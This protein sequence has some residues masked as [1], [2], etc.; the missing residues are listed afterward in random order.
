M[1]HTEQTKLRFIH[2]KSQ[3]RV[4]LPYVCHCIH[5]HT[6]ITDKTQNPCHVGK[7]QNCWIL[8]YNAQHMSH[9]DVCP[10]QGSDAPN[11]CQNEHLHCNCKQPESICDP[12]RELP[13]RHNPTLPNPTCMLIIA[14]LHSQYIATMLVPSPTLPYQPA[15]QSAQLCNNF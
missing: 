9:G 10:V 1:L 14:A 11:N 2:H 13:T 7:T 15:K 6:A 4:H 5:R 12:R 8:Q 3:G